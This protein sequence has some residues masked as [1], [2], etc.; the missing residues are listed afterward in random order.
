MG[1]NRKGNFIA[2]NTDLPM[3][4]LNCILPYL[5]EINIKADK[6]NAD[7]A[8]GI[9]VNCKFHAPNPQVT[10]TQQVKKGTTILDK[11][12][13]FAVEKSLT[14]FFQFIFMEF[15]QFIPMIMFLTFSLAAVI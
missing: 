13:L 14:A 6:L 4:I 12:W 15:P 1:T 3:Q 9:E 2:N 8:S 10:E 11:L 5:Q 7:E